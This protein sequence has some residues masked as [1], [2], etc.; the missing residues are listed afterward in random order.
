MPIVRPLLAASALALIAACGGSDGDRAS[1]PAQLLFKSGF[2]GDIALGAPRLFGN[3]AWQNITGTDS[4]TGFAWPPKIW[5]GTARF[6]LIA[7]KDAIVTEATLR[8]YMFNELQ[9]ATG[10]HGASTRALY[11]EVSKSIA[12]DPD[13]G[14][15]DVGENFGTTQNV[16]VILPGASVQRDLYFSYWLK[17][18]PDLLQRMT[19]NNWA[20][21]VVSDWKTAGDYR[22]LFGVYGDGVNRRLYWHLQGDNVANGGLPQ[23]VFWKQTNTT[24]PVPVGRWFRVEMFV[25]RSG[26]ADGRVWVAV[27][28]QKL[29]DRYGPNMGVNGLSW[30]RIMPFLNYSSGQQLSAYQWAD[31]LEIWDGFPADAAPH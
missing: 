15:V 18:Q 11:S 14:L 9:I 19:A 26:G 6:Q 5:G 25:H 28:G 27:D 4:D 21:R 1:A 10:P 17:F 31:D 20:G 30:N 12:L 24:V 13:L 22:I 16:F 3:G 23:Q 8:D 2:E 29:F 7:G